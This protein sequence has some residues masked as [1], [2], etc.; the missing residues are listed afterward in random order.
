MML[1][2]VVWTAVLC[3]LVKATILESGPTEAPDVE[4]GS[5]MLLTGKTSKCN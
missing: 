3:T 4:S 1:A 5:G 2:P